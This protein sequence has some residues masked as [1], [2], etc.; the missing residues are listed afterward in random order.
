MSSEF[1]KHGPSLAATVPSRTSHC[2]LFAAL[3]LAI[4]APLGCTSENSP[5]VI[6]GAMAIKICR[7]TIAALMMHPVQIVRLDGSDG[8][9]V[10]VS[11]R[12]PDDGSVWKS[13]CKFDGV[14]GIWGADDGRWRDIPNAAEHVTYEFG[15]DAKTLRIRQRFADA[16]TVDKDFAI[17]D[18]D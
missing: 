16:S 14:R 11:Y 18:L 12:R 10:Y 13:K 15:P 8:H 5:R 7:A 3:T 2:P 4:I 6:D 1:S 17:D 9:V